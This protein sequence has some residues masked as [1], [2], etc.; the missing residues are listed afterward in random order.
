[1]G[2]LPLLHQNPEKYWTLGHVHKAPCN[3]KTIRYTLKYLQKVNEVRENEWDDR[4]A[5]FQLMS[6]GLGAS[7]MTPQMVAWYKQTLNNYVVIQGGLKTCLPRYFKDK[8]LDDVEKLLMNAKT[9][10]YIEQK[11]KD[12]NPKKEDTWKREVVRLHNK[13]K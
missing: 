13:R 4:E 1:M 2:G 8:M 12:Y 3:I 5:E 10:N 6:K 7:F 11:D 9:Q